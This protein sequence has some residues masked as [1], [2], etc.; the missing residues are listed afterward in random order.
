MTPYQPS[1]WSDKIVV[2][3]QTYTHTD[4]APLTINDT[5]YV[6]WAAVNNGAAPAETTF[7]FRLY[8][9]GVDKGNWYCPTWSWVFI[10]DH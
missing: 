9:D 1:G 8:I 5:L 2:S 4:D 10:G 3:T 6:D 7:Y